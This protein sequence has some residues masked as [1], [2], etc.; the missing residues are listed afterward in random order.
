M[1]IVQISILVWAIFTL[2][3]AAI[4]LRYEGRRHER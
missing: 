4:L 2:G 1:D 3:V